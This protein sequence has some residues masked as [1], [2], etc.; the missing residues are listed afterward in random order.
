MAHAPLPGI[1]VYQLLSE[2]GWRAVFFRQKWPDAWGVA[3]VG[4]IA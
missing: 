4:H 3:P 1:T 2:L